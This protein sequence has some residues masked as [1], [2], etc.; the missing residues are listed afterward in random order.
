MGCAVFACA[1]TGRVN[2][3]ALMRATGQNLKRL[4]KKH[5]WGRHPFPVE[6]LCAFFLDSCRWLRRPYW[7]YG[8]FPMA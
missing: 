6:A 7:V 1:G 8:L 4:L 2:C 3:E 5:G